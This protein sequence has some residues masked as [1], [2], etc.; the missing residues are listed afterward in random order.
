M[1]TNKKMILLRKTS[2]TKMTALRKK[3]MLL[4]KTSKRKMKA[5][6]RKMMALKRTPRKK[7][8][9]LRKKMMPLKKMLKTKMMMLQMKKR[10]L[11]TEVMTQPQLF[12]QPNVLKMTLHVGSNSGN[13]LIQ[14]LVG[15][16]LNLY[17]Q[18]LLWA[19]S[20]S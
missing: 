13:A 1:T 9:A 16:T 18:L 7:M 11:L 19:L 14:F 8:T 2:K 12:A 4:R 20:V 15:M 3:M 5:L 6:R 10:K 17:H